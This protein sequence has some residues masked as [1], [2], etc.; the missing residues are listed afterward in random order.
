[1]SVKTLPPTQVSD[2]SLI[3][4]HNGINNNP[5]TVN[6]VPAEPED[7]PVNWYLMPSGCTAGDENSWLWSPW[8]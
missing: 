6:F 2:S 8:D 3:P 4:G 1:M 5:A 7:K